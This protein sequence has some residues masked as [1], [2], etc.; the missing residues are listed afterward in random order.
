MTQSAPLLDDA[1]AFAP[2]TIASDIVT[3]SVI[4]YGATLTDFSPKHGQ[5]AGTNLTLS[6][7]DM[8]DFHKGR[9]YRGAIIGR[10]SGRLPG[11]VLHFAGKSYQVEENR[12]GLAAH[13]GPAGLS[14]R[15]WTVREH[16]A[17]RVRLSID[18][19]PSIDGA[20][21]E[22]SITA[23]YSVRGATLCLNL[24]AIAETAGI[25]RLTHHAYWALDPGG[26]VR[27]ALLHPSPLRFVE[28]TAS[29]LPTGRVLTLDDADQAALTLSALNQRLRNTDGLDTQLDDYLIF[30]QSRDGR[31]RLTLTAPGRPIRLH[32]TTNAP[33]VH[34]YDGAFLNAPYSGVALEAQAFPVTN[35]TAVWPNPVVTPGAP[36]T[37][38]MA[39]TLEEATM[40]GDGV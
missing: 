32:M 34:I 7:P 17:D 40:T 28:R 35:Q 19:D 24:S 10:V 1:A 29:K 36:Q 12:P 15:V 9:D 2:L 4:A 6:Y 20:P 37:L 13:G 39:W 30:P 25:L 21:G 26:D 3:A 18:A 22:V 27:E 31:T 33:G 38:S 23:E 16:T 14:E 5:D 8:R 11:G